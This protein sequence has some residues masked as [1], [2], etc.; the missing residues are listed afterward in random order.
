[1]SKNALAVH[2]KQS[3]LDILCTVQWND[4]ML[5]ARKD[6][7]CDALQLEAAPRRASRSGPAW[8]LIMRSQ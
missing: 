6:D 1:M 7:N 3:Q 5:K 2:H 8:V 4:T